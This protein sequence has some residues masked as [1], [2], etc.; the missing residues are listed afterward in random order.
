MF[1]IKTI[2]KISS[3]K[4]CVK[5]IPALFKSP[6]FD[7]KENTVNL[8]IGGGKYNLGTEYLKAYKNVT[9]LVY[10]PYNRSIEHNNNIF[11]L[12]K[13]G[14]DSIS[15]AN[16]LNVIQEYDVRTEIIKHA[17]DIL[18]IGQKIYFQIY[19]GDR[20]GVGIETKNGFKNNLKTSAYIPEIEKIFGNI[21][22]KRLILIAEKYA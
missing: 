20:S 7:L 13:N 17:Y 22:K 10:D 9:N 1:E 18:S 4:T 21:V 16:V 14:I 2:Q 6:F 19:E 12:I 3:K 5:Q 11:S 15:I 8:D